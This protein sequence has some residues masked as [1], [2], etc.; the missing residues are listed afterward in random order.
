MSIY[1]ISN[2]RV[3]N[4]EF[5]NK[6]RERASR[7]FRV[8]E[9]SIN[10]NDSE[11]LPTYEIL[12]ENEMDGYSELRDYMQSEE[13]QQN[14]FGG[15]AAMF[16]ELYKQMIKVKDKQSDC[17]FFIH[18]FANKLEDN[19]E[20]IKKLNEIYIQP[21]D[22]GIDHLIYVAWPS[23]GHKVGTYWNDQNDAEETGRVLGGL[24]SKLHLFF[25]ELFEIHNVER[26][27]NRIHL[28]AH[29]MGNTVLDHMI[30]SIPDSKI[31][32]LF[33][34]V[35]LLHSDVRFDIFDN[36]SFRKLDELG[37]R[38]H[39]YISQSDEVLGGISTYT[40]NFRRRLGFRGPKNLGSLEQE[41]FVVDTTKAGRGSTLRE[42]TLDHWGYIERPPVIHDI[43]Q[44]IKGV[45]ET[46]ISGRSKR[47]DKRN[48]FELD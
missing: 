9:V 26:C 38:T 14:P 13:E 45:D 24:F 44:V 36:G 7:E 31:F 29:S 17:L 11:A 4:N 6:G 3:S 28:A 33:G 47:S 41:T 32:N 16:A 20:H 37:S 19:L 25:I 34:E 18:G 21:E 35:L 8:A 42:K 23:I 40:K 2:R 1:I 10:P 12:N 46:K 15:T 22:S 27:N 5:S 48:Y 43:K 39:I 30:Q